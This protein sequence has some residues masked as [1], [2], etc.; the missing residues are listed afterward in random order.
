MA[1]GIVDAK[2]KLILFELIQDCRQSIHKIAKA[3]GLPKKTAYNRIKRLEDEEV[4]KKYTI[5][6]NYQ[7]LGMNRHSIYIDLHGI[8]PKEVNDYLSYITGIEDISCCYMLHEV[9]RWKLYVSIWTKT[10]GRYDEIQAK[11]LSKFQDHINDYISFQGVRSYTYLARALNTKKRA[12]VDIKEGTGN[13]LL[14]DIDHKIIHE[15]RANS[16]VPFLDLAGKL[17]TDL[18][19]IRR[20]VNYLIKQ[21]IIQRF[22]PILDRNKVGYTE[23]T[24]L[25]RIDASKEKEIQNFIEYARS[26]PRFVII[27]KAVGHANLYYAF[28]AKDDE[29]L[30]EISNKVD[31]LIGDITLKSWKIEVERM[32]S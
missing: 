11:I 31:S 18:S 24:F 7:K 25:S 3:V 19:T 2:D 4:I 26:D 8:D 21:G 15:L 23:Y 1:K 30:K 14:K 22:Y 13:I 28:L 32:V 16:K 12:K 27:I 20:R 29:E 10:I 5:N 9:S 6:V 17:K